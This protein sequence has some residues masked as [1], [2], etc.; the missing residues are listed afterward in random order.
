VSPHPHTRAR[1][2][3]AF[4]LTL[5][6][7]T[8]LV[9]HART[10]FVSE[11]L[12]AT[13][14]REQVDTL[15]K[16]VA[17]RSGAARCDVQVWHMV[18]ETTTPAGEPHEVSA[19]LYAPVAG[20]ECPAP[21]DLLAF[22][23]GTATARDTT[24]SA[25][26]DSAR[27][28]A[29]ANYVIQ[30]FAAQGYLVVAPDYLGFA[31]S[32]LPFHPYL[33][34]ASQATT[35]IDAIRAARQTLE[36]R[37]VPVTHRLFLAGYSQGGHAALATLRAIEAAAEP[38]L[39][40]TAAGG[41]SGPY[42][43][44]RTVRETLDVMWDAVAP[45]DA[46]V[47]PYV[48]TAYQQVYGDLYDTP[49]Q[50]FHLPYAIGIESL[51]PTRADTLPP[52]VTLFGPPW[53]FSLGTF[54]WPDFDSRCPEVGE[55]AWGTDCTRLPYILSYVITDRVRTDLQDPDSPVSRS[56]RDNDLVDWRPEAPV[57]MCGGGRDPVVDFQNSLDAAKRMQAL[58]ARVEWVDV[59]GVAAFDHALSPKD[60]K[61]TPG[62]DRDDGTCPRVE[63]RMPIALHLREA[64]MWATYHTQKVPPLCMH[65]VR[66]SL[67]APLR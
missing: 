21:F 16:D 10:P 23:R 36:R 61:Y 60:S 9:G 24:M 4:A 67:F 8:A 14:T 27:F 3:R 18:Y 38:G 33:H 46:L 2:V 43:V 42:H 12:I 47:G 31:H 44:D 29:I 52:G 25:F 59:E 19:A 45:Q 34:A 53:S 51:L 7:A 30:I 35:T 28:P 62:C 48:L 15:S 6:A 65:L 64:E 41:M 54:H 66:E 37:S 22:N 55:V 11:S 49:E 32:T 57:L 50:Y 5:A 17:E 13:V 58:G 40:V 56:L 20:P 26:G 39:V 63:L 1:F